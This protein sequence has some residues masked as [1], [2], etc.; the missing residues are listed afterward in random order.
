MK[1]YDRAYFDRWYR[2]PRTRVH[3]AADVR[4]KVRMVVGVAEYMLGRPLR[5]VLDVGCGEGAWQPILKRLRPA[6]RYVGVDPSAYAVRR[7][8]RRR[9]IRLG[10]LER[11]DE[12]G[13]AG[14]FDLVVC[15]DVLHYVPAD[16]LAR[17]LRH[18]RDLLGGV[19]YLEMYTSD[20]DIE[21]DVRGW[22][23]RRPEFYR[24]LARRAA[25]TP[26]GLHCYLSAELAR[27]AAALERQG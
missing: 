14:P 10:S 12:A 13:L 27:T 17:G 5:F 16:A 24:R 1:D 6:A 20:D 26:C 8:G 19:A 2:A 23:G 3:T 4:R 7:F 15:C 11:L 9:N 25:L 21:G 22:R 18:V